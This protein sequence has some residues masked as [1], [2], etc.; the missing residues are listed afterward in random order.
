IAI[1][2]EVLEA[3]SY[4]HKNGI[5]HRDLK[6]DNIMLLDEQG[7]TRVKVLDF[8]IA[9]M[10]GGESLT[11]TG[12]GFG[13]PAYMPPERMMG[14]SG[15]DPRID[16]YSTGI[17]LYEMLSGKCPFEST[18]TD[19]AAYWMEMRSMHESR[20]L[21]SLAALGVP[22]IADEIVRR[23]AAKR[24]ADRYASADE[25]LADLERRGVVQS[26]ATEVMSVARLAVTTMPSKASIY[27]DE[28]PRGISDELGKALIDGLTAGLHNVR[29]SKDGY[30]DYRISVA[31]ESGR[32]TDLQVALAARSTV[33]AVP[34]QPTAVG[35]FE[36]A[37]LQGADDLRTAVVV[38]DSLPVGTN[39]FVGTQSLG[40]A[41]EDGKATI[42]LVPGDHEIRIATPAGTSASRRIT[43]TSKDTGSQ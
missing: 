9:R 13:T 6:P 36:T 43:L 3:L 8:G 30:Q 41:G 34:S 27:V 18:A 35:G 12:E 23:A 32:Q 40:L 21:P 17:I 39:V 5:I 16:I 10:V 22:P 28:L 25:M 42:R 14:L 37:R 24:I 31:L 29:V 15:D 38:I 26:T 1:I 2:A 20:P 4:A 11:Q 7:A 19:P 33:A